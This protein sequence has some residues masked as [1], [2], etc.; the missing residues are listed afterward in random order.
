MQAAHRLGRGRFH[1][2][3]KGID[4]Q[5][6]SKE[7]TEGLDQGSMDC[8]LF[9]S[10][11]HSRRQSEVKAELPKNIRMAPERQIDL[12]RAAEHSGPAPG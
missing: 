11:N 7:R 2:K 3:T 1:E 10:L 4:H 8:I 12:F 6:V 9:P 5:R